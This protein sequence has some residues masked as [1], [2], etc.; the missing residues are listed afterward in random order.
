MTLRGIG[1]LSALVISI[2]IACAH[3]IR[4]LSNLVDHILSEPFVYRCNVPSED[5]TNS[6]YRKDNRSLGS[7]DI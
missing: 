5:G 4:T 3:D 7:I 2:D 6:Y 1:T